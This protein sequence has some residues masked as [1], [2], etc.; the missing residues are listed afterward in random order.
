MLLGA[1]ASVQS[2]AQET[3]RKLYVLHGEGHGISVVDVASQ[4]IIKEIEI[5]KE[6]HGVAAPDSQDL[7]YVTIEGEG[8]LAIIDTRS[9]TVLKR[10]DDLGTRP[11]E[12][13]ITSDGRIMYMPF[14]GDGVYRVFDTG[15]RSHRG[16]TDEGFSSQRYNLPGRSLRIP[17]ANGSR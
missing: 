7:L 16:D 4:E 17:F 8:A 14:L 15:K 5:G 6:P 3:H 1:L 2:D 12:N 10:Y 9:D 13:D 11:H